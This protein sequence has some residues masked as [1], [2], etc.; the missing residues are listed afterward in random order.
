MHS[1]L[2]LQ[3][4]WAITFAIWMICQLI[5]GQQQCG[6][7]YALCPGQQA[8]EG[9]WSS[10]EDWTDWEGEEAAAAG[11]RDRDQQVVIWATVRPR[12]EEL[13]KLLK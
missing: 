11:D 6:G 3:G 7:D 2:G 8:E 9:L 4:W 12:D 5:A 10:L 1:T 13:I